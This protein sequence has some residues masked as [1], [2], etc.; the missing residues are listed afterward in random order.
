VFLTTIATAA[1]LF[2]GPSQTS[3]QLESLTSR[4][5]AGQ[6]IVEALPG[7][8]APRALLR[9][10]RRGEVAGVILFARNVGSKAQVR[11]LVRRLQS[12]PRPAAVDEPLLVMVDQEGGLVKRLPGAPS[13]S[14]ATLGR[15][16][17]VSLAR[18]TGTATARNLK[19]YR[20]N[21][22]LAP[23]MDI[24]RRGT[25]Q[26]RTGRSYGATARTV[27]RIGGAF[28]AGLEAGGVGATLKH[29]P[30][31]G[32]VTRDEDMVVQRVPTSLATLRRVDEAPFKSGIGAGARLVMTSTALY[33]ALD[34][35]RPAL[36]SRKVTTGEL[37]DRLGFRGV[38]IT[39]DLDVP[40]LRRYG[41]A[42]TLGP[43]AAGAGNDLLLYCG[44][45]SSGPAGGNAVATALRRGK[46][47]RAEFLASVRRVLALRRAFRP[48]G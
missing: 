33:S 18:R 13:R 14:P 27:G 6:R 42:A 43:A 47:N 10:I 35:R 22:N 38:I 41:N 1:A 46:L 19:A 7:R 39:D 32:T 29:F 37:R 12:E 44:G 25:Y 21:V 20:A 31:L 45:G 36:L 17:S 8:S 3:G 15:A 34:G 28:V 23:V 9:R 4:Q 26:R 2:G 40:A 16:G 48:A 30:G 5:L 11:A 24:G